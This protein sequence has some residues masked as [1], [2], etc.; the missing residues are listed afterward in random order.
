MATTVNEL[1]EMKLFIVGHR[2]AKGLEPENTIRSIKR[3][4]ALGV[5]A[6]EV[7]VRLTKDN[8]PVI[9]HDETLD[10]TTNGKGRVRDYTLKELKKFNAGDNEKIPTLEEVVKEVAGKVVLFIEIKEDEAVKP[11]LN[12]ADQENIWPYSIFISFNSHHIEEVKLFNPKAYTGL[13]YIKPF[14]GIVKAKKMGANMVLPYFRIATA[15][16]IAF[17]KRL[18]LKVVVWTINDI[19]TALEYRNRGADGITTDRPDLLVDIKSI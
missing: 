1:F 19:E 6:V 3:A 7:D 14:D 18:K 17:A 15:K 12:L 16:A 10:R 5:D 9:M 4:I 2:G 11:V 13:I 8:I